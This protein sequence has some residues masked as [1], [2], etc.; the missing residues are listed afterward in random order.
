MAYLAIS[1]FKYGLDRRRP[2]VAGIPGTIWDIKNAHLSRGGDIERAKKFVPLYTLPTGTQGLGQ[3]GGQ[4]YVFGSA[5]LASSMPVGVQYQRLQAPSGSTMTKIIDVRSFDGKLYVIANYADGTI[6]HFYNGSRVTAWDSL[7]DGNSSL[8]VI[9]SY[10]AELLNTRSDVVATPF[11]NSIT[12]RAINAGT[13]FS[14]SATSTNGGAAND[15]TVTASTVQSNAV[16]VAENL[17]IGTVQI[18]GG[19]FDPGVN[20]VTQVTVNGVSLLVQAVSWVTSNSATATALAQEINNRT[21]LHGYTAAASGATV[22]I[23]APPGT[24]ASANGRVVATTV[25]GNT[26]TAKTNFSGGV[27]AVSAVAQVSLVAFAGTFEALDQFTLTVNGT[28]YVAT[29]RAAGH[30]SAAFV[31][32]RRVWSPSNSLLRYCKINTPSDWTDTNVSSGAGFIN[33]ANESEGAEKLTAAA[34][35]S[36]KLAVF[37]PASIRIY[38]ANTDAQLLS[39][40]QTLSNTGTVAKRSIVSYGN[41]DVFYLDT[42]GIRSLRARDASNAA[43]VSDIG[44]SVDPFVRA[45]ADSLPREQVSQAVGVVEPIDGRFW[46]AMGPRIFVLSYFPGSKISAWSYYEPGF[47]VTDFARS[48]ERLYAR[49]GNTIYLYGGLTGQEYPGEDEQAVEIELPFMSAQ[50]EASIKIITGFDMTCANVWDVELLVDANDT[51]KTV[52]VGRLTRSSGGS[53]HISVPGRTNS[54]AV[55]LRCAA[56]GPATIS[57]MSIHFEGEESR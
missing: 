48:R 39:L 41:N 52:R 15:Q 47:T 5:D 53:P 51:A 27:T 8:A 54:F 12:I 23:T 36:G 1:D 11:G 21:S 44:T 50:K 31:F 28:S 32:K 40:V 13:A 3:V 10:L 16:A 4:L 19:T 46:L 38:D 45:Y 25:S 37:S 35:Y 20:T 49:A 7:A 14:I 57:S 42:T 18:T 29:G 2:R 22:S 56:S 33:A 34:E 24:G 30:G 17:A 9:A 55:K 26:T 43:F 6:H